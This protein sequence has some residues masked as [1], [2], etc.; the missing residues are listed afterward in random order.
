MLLEDREKDREMGGTGGTSST[1]KSVD[2]S[3]SAAPY[4]AKQSQIRKRCTAVKFQH[5]FFSS[6]FSFFFYPSSSVDQRA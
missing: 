5:V 2:T 3:N 6:F 4:S 1:L